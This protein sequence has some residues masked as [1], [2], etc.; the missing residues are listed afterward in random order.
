[1]I[2]RRACLLADRHHRSADRE[3][4]D[5]FE[6]HHPAVDDRQAGGDAACLEGLAVVAAETSAAPELKCKATIMRST[7]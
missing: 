1:M 5:V 2:G 3:A 7:A 4:D 6:G